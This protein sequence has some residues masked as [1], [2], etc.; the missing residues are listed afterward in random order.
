MAR[1]SRK[2]PNIDLII[3]PSRDTVGYIRLSVRNED[4]FSSIESQKLIIEEWGHQHQTP[5]MHYY[6]DN[7]FSGNRFDR[8]AFQ[9]MIQDILAGK[10]E[11]IVVKD[12]SRLGRDYITVGYHLEIFFPKQRVRFVSINDQFDTVDG[13]TNQNKEIPIQSRVRIPFINLFNEQVSIETKIKVKESLDMKAQRGEFVGPRAPFGYQKSREN[14]DQLI[15]DPAAAIIVQK[16][17]EMAANGTGVTGIVRY[18]NEQALPTPIQYARSKGLSENYDDGTGNWNS[19]SVKYILTNR[20]YTGMLVQG[21]EKRVVEATHEPLVNSGTFDA[22]QKAFQSRAYNVVPQEQSADNILKSK[23]VCGCCGGKM[24]R[25]RGTNHADWYFFTCITKNRLGADKCTGMYAREED[26]FNAIYCQLKVYASE[27]YITA[28]QH[29]QEIQQFNDKIFEL[30]QGS[31]KAWTNAMEHYEQYVQG[32]ISKEA[33]RAALD[34]AHE[35][36]AVLAGVTE[37]KAACEKEY[38]IFRKLLS[39]SDKRISLN[40]IMDC[41][42]KIVVD[43]GKKIMVKWNIS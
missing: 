35:A 12:L 34:A 30:A 27:H 25:K 24:Q 9:Q 15:P 14:P 2:Y 29:K 10:I 36:K 1:K 11:C 39:A 31:E 33:L 43:V 17:F 26:I 23:V 42:E 37:R 41:V 8:P 20:T 13:I 3:K 4:S 28:L 7:G 32:E 22:I 16:I 18:L 19:R 38:S 21:K 6:I 40:E 5:I